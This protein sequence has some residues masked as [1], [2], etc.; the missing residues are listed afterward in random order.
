MCEPKI[1]DFFYYQDDAIGKDRQSGLKSNPSDI[2]PSDPINGLLMCLSTLFA[3]E[4]E[5][6]WMER[7]FNI[8]TVG[9]KDPA[10]TRFQ[11]GPGGLLA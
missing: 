11:C 4:V 6:E 9:W 8:R 10:R 5:C 7:I 1:R 2:F 3:K